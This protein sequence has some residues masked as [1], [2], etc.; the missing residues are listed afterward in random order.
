MYT[1]TKEKCLWLDYNAVRPVSIGD[2]RVKVKG[3]EQLKQLLK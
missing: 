3:L 1:N 2:Y